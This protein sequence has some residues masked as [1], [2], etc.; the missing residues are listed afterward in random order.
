MVRMVAA[1]ASASCSLGEWSALRAHY[2][3]PDQPVCV[4]Y[5]QPDAVCESLLV[6]LLLIPQPPFTALLSP[7]PQAAPKD[8]LLG[9]WATC[10]RRPS[11]LPLSPSLSPP[12]ANKNPTTLVLT[13]TGQGA[14]LDSTC[15]K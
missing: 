13:P 7:S 2:A 9:P 8:D 5:S 6:V 4:D 12:D 3:L 15:L 1:A 14:T 11:P 10:H